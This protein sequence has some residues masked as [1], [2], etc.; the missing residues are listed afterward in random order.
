MLN[1]LSFLTFLLVMGFLS[2]QNTP[3]EMPTLQTEE[4]SEPVQ[5]TVIS[6]LALGDSYT[7]GQS[8]PEEK[9]WPTQL[10][11]LL[12]DSLLG[13]DMPRYIARTG[14]TTDELQAA[15]DDTSWLADTFDLVSLLIGV[16]N[17]YRGYPFDQYVREFPALLEQALSLAQGN[18]TRVFVVSIPDYGV[19]PFGQGSNPDKIARE[20]DAYNAF[21]KET[22]D[23]MGIAFYNITDISREAL[24]DPTLVASD[25][26]H[27]S[28]EM[29]RRWV[30]EVVGPGVMEQLQD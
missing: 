4:P 5:D 18:V 25:N 6:Y 27:P 28:A 8:V 12:N 22:A 3:P 11:D 29:Y 15:M 9:R 24:D 17:Q 1:R 20:L 7:I 13:V 26:L 19:T 16:N 23:S 30:D 21:A 14:W 2:C 10:M